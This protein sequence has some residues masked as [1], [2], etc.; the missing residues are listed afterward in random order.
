MFKKTIARGLTFARRQPLAVRYGIDGILIT[1]GIT[2]AA[3]N[4]N[5]FAQR[6]G[7]GDFQL[8]ML[9]FLPQILMLFLLIPAGLF[10]GS[11]KNKRIMITVSL[12]C[13]GVFFTLAGS[14]AFVPIHTVYFFLAFLALANVSNG[15][16]NLS[17]QGYFPEVVSEDEQ[18]LENRNSVITFRARLIMIVNFIVP[19]SVGAILTA[20]PSY[21]GKIAAHQVF[22]GLAAV[23]LFSNALHFR[24]IKATK[25]ATPK[26]VSFAEIK[27]ATRR[28][29]KNKP[30]IIFTVMI[31]FFH[32]T[33]QAD[34]TL[35]FIGQANYMHMNE[36]MISMGAVTATAAQLITLKFWSRNNARQ[37]VEKPLAYGMFSLA[38]CPLAMIIGVSLPLGVGPWVFLTIHFMGH[39]GFANITL[40]LFQ[41]LLKVVDEEYRS[42]FISVYTCIITLSNALMPVAGVAVYRA[43][44]GNRQALIYTFAILFF[45]RV[46]AGALWLIR[47]KFSQSEEPQAAN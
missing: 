32:M 7:A 21:D 41:C 9:Q 3:N 10:A 2:M 17:W 6:L 25:P 40:N 12:L 8:S 1:G 23:M 39:L 11:L 18:A 26:R 30:F 29:A 47:C 31:L 44:G 42:L 45:M 34:W 24:K 22:Y 20:I 38:L 19:L 4:N 43:F 37:G 28:M 5:L 16:Y 46:L 35:Y 15:M 13:A 33:W 14:A 36:L 27:E